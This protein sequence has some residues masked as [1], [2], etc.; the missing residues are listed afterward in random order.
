MAGWRYP[1]GY[2]E[3]PHQKLLACSKS[4]FDGAFSK[5]FYYGGEGGNSPLARYKTT[6]SL[7]GLAYLLLH[8]LRMPN[9]VRPVAQWG[10]NERH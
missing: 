7:K 1:R 5:P 6:Q 4:L 10:H 2:T 3:G 8:P 9:D